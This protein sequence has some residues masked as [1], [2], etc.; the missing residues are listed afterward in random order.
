MKFFNQNRIRNVIEQAGNH[1][2]L[3]LV[4]GMPLF[5]VY[6]EYKNIQKRKAIF[7]KYGIESANSN[8]R[9][10]FDHEEITCRGVKGVINGRIVDNETGAIV[11][12]CP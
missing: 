1:A 11:T 8:N 7:E 10:R 4:V 5:V 9:Y 6:D 2:R 12:R 3:G